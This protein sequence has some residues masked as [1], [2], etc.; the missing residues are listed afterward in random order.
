V[1]TAAH[2]L[3]FATLMALCAPLALAGAAAGDEAKPPP[4]DP[5][6]FPDDLRGADSGGDGRISLYEFVRVRFADFDTVDSNRDGLLSL[7]EVVAVYER[8]GVR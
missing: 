1:K 3:R 2:A 6:A 8:G 7:E 4:Y 5:V